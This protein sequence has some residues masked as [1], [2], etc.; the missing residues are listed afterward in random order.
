MDGADHDT[1]RMLAMPAFR[2][3]PSTAFVTES[4]VPLAREIVDR[5]ADRGECDLV[6]EFTAVLPFWAI[7]RKLGLPVGSESRHRAWARALLGYPADPQSALAASREVTRALEPLVEERRSAPRDDVLSHLLSA[8]HKGLRLTDEEVF[9]HVRLL[10]AVGAT[11]TSDAMSSLF[12]ALLTEPGLLDRARSDPAIRP[13]I[14]QESLRLEPPVASLPRLASGGEIAGTEVPPGSFVIAGIAAANRDPEVYPDPDR[15][16][17]D[18]EGPDVLTFGS[19]SKFCPGAQLGRRQL[20]A[21][22]EVVLERLPGLRLV[23]AAEP[24]GAILRSV[25][26]LRVKWDPPASRPSRRV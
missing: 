21:A 1:Y 16:D 8:E 25:A 26:R 11:T 6:A 14:V 7:S 12:R 17:P 3:R 10:F 2:S 5:F 24:S 4:L 15:F 22:L 19:G 18:R 9:S 13:R 23:E 20:L